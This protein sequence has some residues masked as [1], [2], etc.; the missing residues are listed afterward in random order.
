MNKS[1]FMEQLEAL[2]QGVSPAERQEALQY[3]NDYFDDAGVENEDEVIERL[4]SPQEI[5]QNIIRD[6]NGNDI[7]TGA[8]QN[9]YNN[10]R[11]V[12]EYEGN[13]GGQSRE[14]GQNQWNGQNQYN[15]QGTATNN[16]DEMSGGTKA[17]L[18]VLAVLSFPI[19]GSLLA[20]VFATVFGMVAA[21]FGLVVASCACALA[22]TISTIILFIVGCMSFSIAP[23]AG[24]A[25]LGMG[26][27]AASFATLFVMLSVLMCGTATPAIC[28]GVGYLFRKIF[29]RKKA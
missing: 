16:K 2:L 24:V 22:F 29:R 13:D 4:G 5:A 19:W 15:Q 21:W 3:Y 18:I 28:R 20:A 14:N 1:A 27:I 26:L 25:L 11:A 23:M 7:P 9:Q 6:I 10:S 8:W 17:L 12:T